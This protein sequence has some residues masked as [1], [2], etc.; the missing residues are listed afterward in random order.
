MAGNLR[1]YALGA[2]TGLIALWTATGKIALDE[3][4]SI[5]LL[6]PIAILIGADYIKHKDDSEQGFYT[7][8]SFFFL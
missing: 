1:Y 2:Y 8:F 7:Y 5:A 4:S 6:A 3:A